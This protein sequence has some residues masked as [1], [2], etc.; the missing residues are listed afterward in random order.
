MI[1]IHVQAILNFHSFRSDLTKKKKIQN[2]GMDFRKGYEFIC[3]I[4]DLYAT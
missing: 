4:K 2:V 3:S 1:V